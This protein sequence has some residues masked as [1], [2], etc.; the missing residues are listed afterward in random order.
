MNL[1][2][3]RVRLGCDRFFS[4]ISHD[5]NGQMECVEWTSHI[6]I[7][8]ENHPSFI[9]MVYSLT[10]AL[11]AHSSYLIRTRIQSYFSLFFSFLFCLVFAF[12]LSP[13]PVN[14]RRNWQ[15]WRA[16]APNVRMV[17]GEVN[18]ALRLIRFQT[19]SRHQ[20]LN[21]RVRLCV[22]DAPRI[23]NFQFN[24]SLFDAIVEMSYERAWA[25][26]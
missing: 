12:F 13:V 25:S 23:P 11:N 9:H 7:I 17:D 26:E 6:I 15:S 4:H 10:Y 3:F 18:G 5:L 2:A 14:G 19:H 21:V 24:P 22:S 16:R 1:I 20:E 8:I